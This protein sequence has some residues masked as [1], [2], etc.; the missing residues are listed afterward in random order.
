M[1][2]FAL[3]AMV[4]CGDKNN[5]GGSNNGGGDNGGRV[6]DPEDKSLEGTTW[7]CRYDESDGY[8]IYELSFQK[9]SQCKYN[10]VGYDEDGNEDVSL[11]D[12]YAGTYTYD[13]YRGTLTMK[14][15]SGSSTTTYDGTFRVEEDY[16]QVDFR[17][18]RADLKQV[19]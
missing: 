2:A 13:G 14:K 7:Q 6:V 8:S 11:T 4:A 19:K 16:L 17:E 3:T 18:E 15:A 10:I 5:N 9:G 12:R 1:V